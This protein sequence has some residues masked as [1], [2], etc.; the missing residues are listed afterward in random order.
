MRVT[1][2]GLVVGIGF[3]WIGSSSADAPDWL[4]AQT[5]SGPLLPP[6]PSRRAA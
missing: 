1:L 3:L 5:T 2:R 6:S 4:V